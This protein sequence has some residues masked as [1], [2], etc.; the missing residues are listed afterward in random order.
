MWMHSVSMQDPGNRKSSSD[1]IK[2]SCR[3]VSADLC[4]LFARQLPVGFRPPHLAR[5]ALHLEVLVALRSAEI[6]DLQA[7]CL[8]RPPERPLH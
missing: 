2:P 6:E 5:I 4:K 1:D 7:S 3:R 8:L